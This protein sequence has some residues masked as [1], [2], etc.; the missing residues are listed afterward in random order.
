MVQSSQICVPFG[1]DLNL[2]LSHFAGQLRTRPTK[3]SALKKDIESSIHVVYGKL[4]TGTN[5]FLRN[6]LY[7]VKSLNDEIDWNEDE[8]DQH[9][10]CEMRN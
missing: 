6:G 9:Y 2:I 5:R 4:L 1:N 10:C 7:E 8:D 3:A